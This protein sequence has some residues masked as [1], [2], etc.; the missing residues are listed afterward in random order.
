MY[1]VHARFETA[2]EIPLE[3]DVVSQALLA[4]G[5]RV[6]HLSVHRRPPRHFVFGFYLLAD[7]LAEAEA[8]AERVSR[9][10]LATGRLPPARLLEAEAPLMPAELLGFGCA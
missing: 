6:E 9:R 8:R 2:T 7:A 5:D 10:L 3:L 4:P 1:L